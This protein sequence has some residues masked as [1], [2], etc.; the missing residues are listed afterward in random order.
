M[1]F[2][3]VAEA[4]LLIPELEKVFDAVAELTA[5][6]E[7][8]AGSLRRRQATQ[9][10]D[11]AAS[12]IERAQLQFL[13][14]GINQWLQKIVDLGAL[15]KGVDPA[16]VDFPSRLDGREVYLCWKLGDKKLTHYHAVGEGFSNRKPLPKRRPS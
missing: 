1:K 9:D 6:A 7:V 12:A 16:L 15:P 14:S 4:E 13:A 5:Q 10:R 11:P 8:K 2:F 3:T